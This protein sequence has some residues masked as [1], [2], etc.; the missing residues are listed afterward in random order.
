MP[1]CCF[2]LATGTFPLN[3]IHLWAHPSIRSIKCHSRFFHDNYFRKVNFRVF[4]SPILIHENIC[5]RTRLTQE[6]FWHITIH[7]GFY[8]FCLSW[9]PQFQ[10]FSK[11]WVHVRNS[12]FTISR[13]SLR[14]SQGNKFLNLFLCCEFSTFYISNSFLYRSMISANLHWYLQSRQSLP[15][16]RCYFL[17]F[18]SC[19]ILPFT[20]ASTYIMDQKKNSFYKIS[21]IL[22]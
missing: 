20:H 9:L 4:L 3:K 7:N 17:F 6:I 2:L 5:F 13:F 21:V 16:W 1:S 11:T 22:R 8:T 14:S 10:P 15:Q 18:N 12:S 19:Y